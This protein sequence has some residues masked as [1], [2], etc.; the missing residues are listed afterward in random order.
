MVSW[1]NTPGI[2][3]HVLVTGAPRTF[4]Q[5]IPLPG[6]AVVYSSRE[7]WETALLWQA[8]RGRASLVFAPGPQLL[9]GHPSRLVHEL[10]NLMNVMILR[11]SDTPII[12]LG[13]ALRG[14]HAVAVRLEQAI[15]ARCTLYLARDRTSADVLRRPLQYVPDVALDLE[16]CDTASQEPTQV[17]VSPRAGEPWIADWFAALCA[18]A[19]SAGREVLLVTQVRRDEAFHGWLAARE[20]V[21]HISWSGQGHD[22]QLARVRLEYGRSALVISDRLHALLLGL[23]DGA[24]PVGIARTNDKK[25][26]PTLTALGW[27]SDAPHDGASLGE[28]LAWRQKNRHLQAHIL[29]RAQ[30]ELREARQLLRRALLGRDRDPR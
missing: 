24:T 15:H 5:A 28:M 7:S 20:R 22:D 1:L 2:Q 23:V 19:R 14:Q 11:R 8:T 30:H 25:I 16:S 10:G 13:R 4:M 29:R 12:K 26:A 27:P 6:T 17:A 18:D 3:L 21:R 9:D